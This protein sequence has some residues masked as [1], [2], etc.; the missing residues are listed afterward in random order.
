MLVDLEKAIPSS[1]PYH[2]ILQSL[3]MS[4]PE[5]P[6]RVGQPVVFWVADYLVGS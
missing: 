2:P 4:R 1:V 6:M 5:W 3:N